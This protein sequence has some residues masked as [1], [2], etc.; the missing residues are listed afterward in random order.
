SLPVTVVRLGLLYGPGGRSIG[1]GLAEIG[2]FR[3]VIG[4]EHN[5]LPYTHAGNAVDALL[6]AAL[7]PDA[8]GKVYN[9]VDEQILDVRA[10]A[11]LASNG[12]RFTSVHLPQSLLLTGARFLEW[13]ARRRGSGAPPRFSRYVDSIASRA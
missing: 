2:R 8:A 9:V 11:K 10:A 5:V 1:R 3:L 13:R 7:A 12:Q 6:L 4:R